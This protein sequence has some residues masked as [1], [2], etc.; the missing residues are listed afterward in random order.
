MPDAGRS[1]NFFIARVSDEV[2]WSRGFGDRE[3]SQLATSVTVDGTGVI[4]VTGT[5]WGTIDVGGGVQLTNRSDDLAAFL[6]TLDESGSLLSADEIKGDG[7]A[8]LWTAAAATTPAGHTYIAGEV[9]GTIDVPG[10]DAPLE[11]GTG[12]GF[13][14]Q[15]ANDR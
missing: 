3:T 1:E 9:S 8:V 11:G 6:L 15:L 5:F 2:V 4:Y 10:I 14:V 12:K 7:N 13:F